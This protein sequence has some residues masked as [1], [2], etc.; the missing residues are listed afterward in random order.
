MSAT[1]KYQSITKE[2]SV[3]RE[4]VDY[5]P[6]FR[7]LSDWDGVDEVVSSLVLREQFE[8][9][10]EGVEG[11]IDEVLVVDT[12]CVVVGVVVGVVGG[13]V[14]GVVVGVVGG[15]GVGIGRLFLEK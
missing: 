1:R 6:V 2:H 4:R 5:L 14:G 9:K 13:V 3:S 15:G 11:G 8:D 7:R 10:T 12:L